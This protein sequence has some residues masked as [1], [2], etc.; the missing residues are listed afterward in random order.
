MNA[1]RI[2]GRALSWAAVQFRD[3]PAVVFRDRPLTYVQIEQRSNQFA[4]ALIGL[5]QRPGDISQIVGQRGEA[6][7]PLICRLVHVDGPVDLDLQRVP[8]GARTVGHD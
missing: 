8:A 2:A 3:R 7:A 6:R 4:N 5:G 1:P